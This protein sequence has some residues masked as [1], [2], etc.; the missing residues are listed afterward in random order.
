[1]ST[2]QLLVSFFL[3]PLISSQ[4]N[5]NAEYVSEKR[6]KGEVLVYP[7]GQ[8]P[9]ALLSPSTSNDT[10]SNSNGKGKTKAAA[11]ATSNEKAGKGGSEAIIQRQTSIFSWKD[12]VYDIKIKKETR[13]ILDHVDGW[14][15][16]GTLTALMVGYSLLSRYYILISARSVVECGTRWPG[17]MR[18][19][20]GRI[21]RGQNY[22]SRCLSY[23]S[24]HGSCNR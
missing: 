19:S 16:P 21:W 8:I 9:A 4:L 14:V 7:K 1:V 17:L 12:V 3:P 11:L 6:S 13:R 15:K 5:P 24:D 10:E 23:K 22:T 2:S 18:S 20:L